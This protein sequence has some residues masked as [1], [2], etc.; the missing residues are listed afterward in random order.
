MNLLQ[1]RNFKLKYQ[2]C[3]YKVKV[4]ESEFKKKNGHN[5]T[6]DDIREA[7]SYV[8]EAY[9]KYYD[10]KTKMLEEL[11]ILISEEALSPRNEHA[12][13]KADTT[14]GAHIKTGEANDKTEMHRVAL[15][16]IQNCP[17]TTDVNL[18]QKKPVAKEETIEQKPVKENDV[19][20]VHLNVTKTSCEKKSLQRSFSSTFAEKLAKGAQ[21]CKRNPRK[22]LSSRSSKHCKPGLFNTLSQDC[23]S[24]SLSV[25]NISFSQE[26]I[27]DSVSLS[28]SL[29]FE[30]CNLEKDTASPINFSS[31]LQT[32]KCISEKKTRNNHPISIVQ[33]AV[34]SNS[35]DVKRNV[36]KGW[37][38]RCSITSVNEKWSF[39]NDN[40]VDMSWDT[41]VRET[42]AKQS[43]FN[44]SAV[45]KASECDDIGSDE[46]IIYSSDTESSQSRFTLKRK[47]SCL[48]LSSESAS[49]N[50][51]KKRKVN[52]DVDCFEAPSLVKSTDT[53]V[54]NTQENHVIGPQ[55]ATSKP[56]SSNEIPA[57]NHDDNLS[58]ATIGELVDHI[59]EKNVQNRK[60]INDSQ[61]KLTKKEMLEKKMASGQAN[62]NFVKVNLK[63]KVYV[64]G[65]KTMTYSK[66]KKLQWK[67]NKR[68]GTLREDTINECGVRKCYK[69]GD[70]GHFARNCLQN[71]GDKLMPES[72]DEEDS[73]YPTLEEAAAMAVKCNVPAQRMSMQVLQDSQLGSHQ[74]N[75][76]GH[77]GVKVPNYVLESLRLEEEK[78]VVDPIYPLGSDGSTMAPTEDVY[79]VLQ[80]FGHTE[81]RRGQAEAIMRILSG[82]STLVTLSTG[83]G[84]S[85]CYQLP[86]LMYARHNKCIT[87]VVSP[88]VSLM[89]DQVAGLPKCIKIAC[90]HYNQTESQR[91]EIMEQAKAGELHALLVSPEAVMSG[92]K[93]GNFGSI[94]QDLPPIAFACIDE[95]HCL[96]Q[97]SHNFR[98]SYLMISEVL[99]SKL[100]VKTFL[101]L[102]ATATF[103]TCRSILE[104]LQIPDDGK[105]VIKNVPLPNNLVLTASCDR[106]RDDALLTLLTGARFASC[107]SIIV[108]C[109]RRTE[110]ERLAV[111]L[112]TCLKEG[113]RPEEKKIRCQVSTNAEP[114]HAGLT[115]ARRRL[116]QK[117]FMSG[118]TRIVVAT[119]AFGMGIDKKDIRAVIHY[120]MP[121]NFESYVQEV[122]RA[123]RDGL[124]AHCHLFLDPDGADLQELGRHIFANSVDRHVIRKLLQRVFVPCRCNRLKKLAESS[125]SE[126]NING[127]EK[128]S[129]NTSVK[130][131]GHEVAFKVNETVQA[132]DI[133]E[134]NIA[135]MLCYLE[136]HPKKWIKVLS[137]VYTMCKVQSYGGPKAFK[138]AAKNSPP[139]AMAVALDQRQGIAHENSNKIEF[140]VVDV[141]AVL[142]WDSGILKSHLKSLEWNNLGGKWKRTR[143]CVEF[144]EL[145]FR[146]LAPGML[147]ADELD[148]ALDVLYERVESQERACLL[149]LQYAF[150]A[151][152]SV[153]YKS[154]IECM[155]SSEESRSDGLK[156]QIR[157]YF[158]LQSLNFDMK[159]KE[160]LMHEDQVIADTRQ[161]VCSYPDTT[162]TGRQ[163]A[164]IFHGIESPC[165]PARS[166]GRCKYWRAHLNEDFKLLVKVATRE[167]LSLR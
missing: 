54:S 70:A 30:S 164:R 145:G 136:L 52:E 154:C 76:N 6:K 19:W 78:K 123:G 149:Q 157:E 60:K 58:Q 17:E 44:E 31:Q 166:W 67:A 130:C 111:L 26:S 160:A 20:G 16:D 42:D 33:K 25:S 14:S 109:I 104:H 89:E 65:K 24:G 2:K 125:Y 133:P 98:P 10:M 49:E 8:R 23:E 151:F 152:K 72:E 36:D 134:E 96:S 119:I 103:S 28:C 57:D 34:T 5:P 115:A 13:S 135:T 51:A 82:L 11:D 87:L 48:S 12:D 62:E 91:K 105:G 75:E 116:V 100:G 38:E 143:I 159:I 61:K 138:E 53:F 74:E 165:F 150:D 99:R 114:Y 141:A 21:F 102:T 79:S 156:K 120:N 167:I 84:K 15:A 40:A 63:K 85:L 161:L 18:P 127:E 29:P 153:A 142:N 147:P 4:W 41:S 158:E 122:G 7:P 106:R 55:E 92:G 66:H 3:K 68:S 132:L 140:P 9:K 71:A 110:C 107:D 95:A 128:I 112:R 137:P 86:A 146:V 139:L 144:Q 148:E 126:A 83:T 117:R 39:M 131:P 56:N 163:V 121:R 93:N 162:F 47:S 43:V 64:R 124:P 1:D 46:E 37:L 35:I 77:R 50:I 80:E 69:C 97:W 118:Q 22:S 108:Y 32:L 73:Q 81:F 155:D 90:L 27:T 113:Q 101:G 94:I 129:S 88:L 59:V 45:G